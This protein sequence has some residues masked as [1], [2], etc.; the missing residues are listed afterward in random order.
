MRG[1][2]NCCPREPHHRQIGGPS[3]DCSERIGTPPVSPHTIEIKEFHLAQSVRLQPVCPPTV[4]S[5]CC[6]GDLHFAH[7]R[8]CGRRDADVLHAVGASSA[9]CSGRHRDL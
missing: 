7:G 6:C 3:T 9:T 5:R 1:D 2:C 4:H 8:C